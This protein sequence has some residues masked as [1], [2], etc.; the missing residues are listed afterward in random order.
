METLRQYWLTWVLVAVTLLAPALVYDRLPDS[1]PIHW[2]ARGEIDGWMAK[3]LGAF[4]LPLVSAFVSL[5]SALAPSWSPKGFEM[6]PVA[7]F[8]PT[9]VA[10][11]AATLLYL[12]IQLLRAAM[13]VPVAMTH[14]AVG[15]VGL[16]FVVIGNYL[17]KSTRNFFFGIR[18]PWTLASDAVWERTHR[19]AAPLLV[20]GGFVMLGSAVF[21][22]ISLP[23][24]LAIV[25]VIVVAPVLQSFLFWKKLDKGSPP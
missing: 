9:M 20:A 14:H 12:T 13:G 16:V 5:V 2:N 1:L 22:A 10:A 11:V 6:N 3:P 23:L 7:R 15:I 21:D 8:Y 18:T 19:F 25:V 24:V 17:G 4:L